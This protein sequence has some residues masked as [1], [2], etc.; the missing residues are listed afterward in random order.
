MKK[1]TDLLINIYKKYGYLFQGRLFSAVILFYKENRVSAGSYEALKHVLSH[2]GNI[3]VYKKSKT[4]S[5]H[6]LLNNC[7]FDSEGCSNFIYT[8]DIY[9]SSRIKGRILGNCTIDYSKILDRGLGSFFIDGDDEFSKT[10]NALINDIKSYLKRL[11]AFVKNSNIDNKASIETYIDRF[12]DEPAQTL[13]EALQRILIVNQLQ[14]QTGHILVGLGRLDKHLDRFM[15]DESV[16]EKLFGEFFSLLHKYFVMKS[17]ALMGDTGQIVILGGYDTD[18]KGCRFR[19]SELM[20][21]VIKSLKL[22]DPKVLI[23]VNKYT[24]RDIW[25]SITDYMSEGVGSPLVSN[26]DVVV[27]CMSEYGYEKKDA[28]DYI[29]SACWEPI[30]AG[31]YEQNNILSLNYLKPLDRVFKQKELSSYDSYEKLLDAYLEQLKNY[32]R[33]TADYLAGLK[34][35]QDPLYSMFDDHARSTHTD[36]AYNGS[37][38]NDYGILTVALANTI[39]SLNNIKK[40]VYEQKRYT[41]SEFDRIR[42]SDFKDNDELLRSLKDADS[43]WCHDEKQFTE[44]VN[45]ITEITYKEL[46]YRAAEIKKRIKTGLSSPHYIMDSAGYPAS[47]DGRKKGDPFS[48]HI[49]TKGSIAYTEIF[50]FAS[51]LDYS[52]GRFNGNTV[53]IMIPSVYIKNNKEAFTTLLKNAFSQGVFQFQANVLDADTL[54]RAKNNPAEYEGLIVRV[55][56]FNAYFNELPTEYKDYLIERAQKSEYAF[57]GHTKILSA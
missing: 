52:D 54:I 14:W 31:C 8:W 11:K 24:D 37:K 19:Y 46:N 25:N 1:L 17:N 32:A 10:N 3:K 44:F 56:G 45:R 22:P 33:E 2:F 20:L 40:L 53:D 57:D 39:D 21:K 41:L 50:N 42:R 36:V 16:A 47:F 9:K 23:R 18:G 15:E 12:M 4:V 29:T 43:L 13:E 51:M 26:D 34:W 28:L 38:Y 48:V 6:E 5:L 30:A 35:E 7:A 49:S 55:W 27:R